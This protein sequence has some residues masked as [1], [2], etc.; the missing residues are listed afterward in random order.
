MDVACGYNHALFLTEE[1][2]V[3]GTGQ[4]STSFSPEEVLKLRDANA[5]KVASGA[6]HAF[7]FRSTVGAELMPT[8]NLSR[9]IERAFNNPEL[10]DV[11]FV[12]EGKKIFVNRFFLALRCEKFRVQFQQGFADAKSQEVIVS[13]VKYQHYFAF[14]RFIYTDKADFPLQ[15]TI[16]ILNLGTRR[17]RSVRAQALAHWFLPSHS[18]PTLF[19]EACS[20]MREA[21]QA[22]HRLSECSVSLPSCCDLPNAAL[23]KILLE[24]HD[25]AREFRF[26][27]QKRI[28]CSFVKGNDFGNFS[29][30]AQLLNSDRGAVI[31]A[32]CCIV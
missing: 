7:A 3:F 9:D 18:Y 22:R 23:E 20:D 10:S 8:S 24:L 25:T 14:L 21:H 6:N 29:R 27:Y 5:N 15:D 12:V 19:D 11:I 16:D 17:S 4:Q 2:R 28:I 31:Q 1:G 26:G 13:D 32:R 30:Q